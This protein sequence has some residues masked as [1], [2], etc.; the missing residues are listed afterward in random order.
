MDDE[1]PDGGPAR[2]AGHTAGE[3]TGGTVHQHPGRRGARL[4]FSVTAWHTQ[5]AQGPP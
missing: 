4:Q 3:E 5:V 1:L 2:L